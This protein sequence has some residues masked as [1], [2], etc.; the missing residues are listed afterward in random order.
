MKHINCTIYYIIGLGYYSQHQSAKN[1]IYRNQHKFVFD[2]NYY[3]AYVINI[4]PCHTLGLEILDGM[5][6]LC[7]Q[8]ALPASYDGKAPRPSVIMGEGGKISSTLF[9]NITCHQ[10]RLGY[11]DSSQWQLCGTN[12]P[13]QQNIGGLARLAQRACKNNRKDCSLWKSMGNAGQ[14]WLVLVIKL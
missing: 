1:S 8:K 13:T 10:I 6:V 12:T 4:L 14:S 3:W 5:F 7:F 2:V 9:A 11:A